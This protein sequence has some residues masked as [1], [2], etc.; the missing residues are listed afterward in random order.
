RPAAHPMT[1]VAD[2]FRAADAMALA[3]LAEGCG[4]SPLESLACGTPVVATEVGGMARLLPG[5]ARLT[6]RRDAE[7]MAR[8][9]LWIAAHREEARAQALR[10]RDFVV[11]E[12]SR[13]KAFA[14]LERSLREVAAASRHRA[15]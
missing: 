12:W 11:R 13:K 10:G 8:E 2:Y 9:F 6:P 7:A 3:S 1:E 14:D 4:I 15:A 5:Y